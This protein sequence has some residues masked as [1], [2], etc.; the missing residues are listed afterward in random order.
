M[1]D[2]SCCCVASQEQRG[3][4]DLQSFLAIECGFI[5]VN[6]NFNTSWIKLRD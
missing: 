4:G 2:G 6:L 3:L 1:M 5:V